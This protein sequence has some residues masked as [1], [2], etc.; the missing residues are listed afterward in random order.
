MLT[1]SSLSFF[2]L[3]EIAQYDKTTVVFSDYRLDLELEGF[4]TPRNSTLVYENSYDWQRE[5]KTSGLLYPVDA[6]LIWVYY[7]F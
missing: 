4:E 3:L 6:L 7:N 1:L 5:N 2:A